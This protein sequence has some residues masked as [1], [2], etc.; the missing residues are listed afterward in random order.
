MVKRKKKDLELVQD[1]LKTRRDKTSWHSRAT[2]AWARHVKATGWGAKQENN[3]NTGSARLR[4]QD[5]QWQRKEKNG[6]DDDKEQE[7]QN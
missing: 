4:S 2:L 5:I 7:A 3:T 6:N 1:E